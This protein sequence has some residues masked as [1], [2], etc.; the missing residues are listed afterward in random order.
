V[1]QTDRLCK[2]LTRKRGCTAMDIATT[3]GSTSPHRRLT[4]LRRK[5]WTVWREQVA[6]K[7]YGRY[8]GKAPA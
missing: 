8:F 5:G 4:D 7:N 3:V 6:G 2:L 1:T